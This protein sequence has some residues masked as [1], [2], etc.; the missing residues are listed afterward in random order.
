MKRI[1]LVI[2]YDG[3]S[4]AGF[5]I[6]K[7]AL[8]IEQVLNESLTRLLNEE[9]HIIGASRTDA[10]VHAL[11]NVAVFDSETRI[12]AEK[13][14]YALNTYLPDDIRIQKSYE[15]ENDFHPR[16][17]NSRKTY[18]YRILNTKIPNPL[19]RANTYFYHR[20]LDEEKM[21]KGAEYLLGE[22]DF[23]AFCSAHAQINDT[24][25]T[26]YEVKV[27][28]S[29][30]IISIRITGNG[31]LYNMV[32]II[33][34]S[35][36]RVGTDAE[37][38]EWI[39]KVLASRD[40]AKAGDCAPA[41]GLTLIEIKYEELPDCIFVQN[42]Q[43]V[44]SLW[45]KEIKEKQKA[46]LTVFGCSDGLKETVS[47]LTKK[48]FRYGAKWFFVRHDQEDIAALCGASRYNTY[49]EKAFFTAGEYRY[50][51][52][53]DIIQMDRD[54]RANPPL[55]TEIPVRVSKITEKEADIFLEIYNKCFFSIPCSISLDR[56]DIALYQANASKELYLISA[57]EKPVG[58]LILEEQEEELEISA[59]GISG[60][61]RRKSYAKVAIEKVCEEAFVRGKKRV[62][63]QVFEN[64]KKAVSLYYKSGFYR[65]RVREKWYACIDT[66]HKK[67]L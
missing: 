31:F 58:I 35:L 24:Y 39:G 21:Q 66:F 1:A 17:H 67:S 8:T 36:I 45:Q 65:I 49:K 18:E 30:D 64:N 37:K 20:H 25:R 15:T 16:Y 5:Q 42:D 29:G 13:I 59:L 48:M 46:Y 28:R 56:E 32:R 14:A 40:R 57:E 23:Q 55:E 11:G 12:P 47:R 43:I 63:L 54:L 7:N 34:G 19:Y 3:S 27:E 6:Q 62:T 41:S 44:Y 38:P 26:I 33:V 22:H 61:A 52:Y 60:P 50:T 9:I 10:G 2:A 4:Y 53:G 51:F